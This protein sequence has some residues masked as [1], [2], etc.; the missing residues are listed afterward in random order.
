MTDKQDA[1]V[2]MYQ[3]VNSFFVQHPAL[4]KD[5][6]VLKNHHNQLTAILED[7]AK[8]N[9]SQEFDSK[10][11]AAEKKKAKE[12]LAEYIFELSSGFCS[13]AIDTKN[14][15]ISEEFDTS[16]S[17]VKRMKDAEFVNYANRLQSELGKYIKDLSPYHITADDITKLANKTTK[18]SDILHI[19]DEV[20]KNKAVATQ[21]IKELIKEA[22]NLLDKSIDRDMVHYKKTDS[23]LYNEYLKRREIHDA[24]TTALSIKGTVV[25]SQTKEPLQHVKVTVK[26]KAGKAWAEKVKTSTHLGNFQFKGIPEGKCKLTFTLEYYDTI[27]VDSVVHSDK[28]TRLDVVLKKTENN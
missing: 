24:P 14:D 1:V 8:Y 4:T 23:E 21:K 20:T 12:N 17:V 26:F 7:I 13:F 27:V 11:Y 2:D 10:G 3:E 28:Y 18:Y 22:H 5:D 19:P 25:D 9:Q 15:V 6:V 16:L